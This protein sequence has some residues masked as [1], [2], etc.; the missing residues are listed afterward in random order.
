MAK[1]NILEVLSRKRDIG[2]S[3]IDRV[4]GKFINSGLINYAI[5][6]SNDFVSG[7]KSCIEGLEDS[8]AKE[9]LKVIADFAA[10]RIEKQAL[11]EFIQH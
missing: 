3:D 7:A 10:E 1:R 11:A 2:S 4:R 8:E 5:Q 9:K 6:L